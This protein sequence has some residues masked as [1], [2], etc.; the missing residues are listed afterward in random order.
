MDMVRFVTQVYHLR[1]TTPS[2]VYWTLIRRAQRRIAAQ[3]AK[4]TRAREVGVSISYRM[5]LVAGM[6]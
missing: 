6:L 1:N 3:V 5:N 2:A 4:G